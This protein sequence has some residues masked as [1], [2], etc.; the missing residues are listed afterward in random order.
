M[1]KNK[2]KILFITQEFSSEACGG[3][4]VYAFE[5]SNA[6]AKSGCVDVHVIAPGV[7]S[8]DSIIQEG[9]YL[10]TRKTIFRPLLQIPSF[11]FQ[12]WR[13]AKKL[14]KE[15]NITTI[16]CN[17]NAGILVLNLLP[18]ITMIHHPVIKEQRFT[19]FNQKLTNLPDIVMDYIVM[20]KSSHLTVPSHLVRDLLVQMDKKLQSKITISQNGIDIEKFKPQNEGMLRTQLCIESNDII[21]FF[22]GGARAKRKGALNLIHALQKINSKKSFKC[23]ISG[24]SR[25]AGWAHELQEEMAKSNLGE[26]FIWTGEIPYQD[27]VHYYSIADFVVYPSL[28]EGFGL[29]LLEAMACGRPIIATRTGEAEYIISSNI[30]GILIN[31][32]DEVGL[33]N[34][35]DKLL[36]NK[37][38]REVMGRAAFQSVKESFSWESVAKI[39]YNLHYELLEKIKK[40]SVPKHYN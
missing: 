37:T 16:H 26:R 8:A 3:A 23:V 22:P 19:T 25:E 12:V 7:T 5:L 21:I 27:L 17:N 28:F 31:I 15:N 32:E 35:I 39:V 36:N 4:G 29:P 1:N 38:T 33:A 2:L 6:L 20:H 30:N 13:S 24:V 14:I 10:H 34:A 40:A 9:L 18:S 11:Y